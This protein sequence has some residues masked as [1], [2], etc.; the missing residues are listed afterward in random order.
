MGL[1]VYLYHCR[2]RATAKAIEERVSA[3]TVVLWDGYKEY[4]KMTDAEKEDIRSKS[5]AIYAAAGCDEWGEHDSVQKIE[6][7][8]AE[9]PEHL[10]K[11]GYFRSSYNGSGINSVFRKIGL[12]DLYGIMGVN[13]SDEYEVHHDWAVCLQNINEAINR[14]QAH[15]DSPIGKFSVMEL[16]SIIDSASSAAEALDIFKK[17]LERS[18]EKNGMFNSYSNRK[19][20]FYLDGLRVHAFIPSSDKWSPMY[21]IVSKEESAEEDWYLQALK[22]MRETCEYVLKQEDPQNYYMHWSG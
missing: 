14:Y 4:N 13:D 8:S 15:L 22:I 12:L 9:Y 3:E 21:V 17:E 6:L 1:D 19:G 5:K 10:F 11:V 16:S 18:N 2:D 7:L 20:D